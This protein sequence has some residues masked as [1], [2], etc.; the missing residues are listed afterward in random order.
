MLT[1]QQPK[2]SS[3]SA[4]SSEILSNEEALKTPSHTRPGLP[5]IMATIK[6]PTTFST[7]PAELRNEIYELSGC[8]DLVQ[9]PTTRKIMPADELQTYPGT[10]CASIAYNRALIDRPAILCI[11]RYPFTTFDR[12]L[13]MKFCNFGKT[14]VCNSLLSCFTPTRPS[15]PSLTKVSTAVRADTLP[16]YYGKYTFYAFIS[17]VEEDDETLL[18][19]LST[20]GP[21]NA[22]LLRN[23]ILVHD[24]QAVAHYIVKDLQPEMARLGVR[25][26]DAVK[27]KRAAYPHCNSNECIRS[28]L[29]VDEAKMTE[30]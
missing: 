5:S 6:P 30:M 7:L 23:I 1:P 10:G 16:I 22:S 26:G 25:V 24:E 9:C 8:L 3:D 4:P 11:C 14:R 2:P 29:I 13:R 12:F 27:L 20:I 19:W 17:D 21:H 28:L 18:R 15:Q